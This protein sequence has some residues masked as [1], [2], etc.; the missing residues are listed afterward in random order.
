MRLSWRNVNPTHFEFFKDWMPSLYKFF[1]SFPH[2]RVENNTA[3]GAFDY[4]QWLGLPSGKVEVIHNGVAPEWFCKLDGGSAAALRET[5]DQTMG[6]ASTA[7]LVVTIGRLSAEKRPL[8]LPD[9]LLALRSHLPTASLIHIGTGPLKN[10][11][12]ERMTSAGL[13]GSS[14]KMGKGTAMFLLDRR[15]DV[16]DILRVSGA[17]LLT[18]VYEGMPNVVMEAMLAGIPVVATRVGGVPDL[19][20]DGVH[21]FLHD[22]GDIAGMAR[23]LERI[24]TNPAL[25]QNMGRAARERILSE[26][27]T[28][29]L[30]ERMVRAYAEQCSTEKHQGLLSK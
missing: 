12:Q 7:P 20:Q 18:S 3:S 30:A 27:T 9:I 19:I 23:S 10:A 14:E 26:F 8:D 21:G 22:V 16:F 28:K 2:I 15:E 29:H 5:M 1:L 13:A 17:L 24:L 25:R 6:I 11:L 4:E